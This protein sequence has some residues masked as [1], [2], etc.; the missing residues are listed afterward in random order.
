MMGTEHGGRCPGAWGDLDP[1]MCHLFSRLSATGH[2]GRIT[3]LRVAAVG[4]EVA[5]GA[6]AEIVWA[7]VVVPDDLLPYLG[8][9][10]LRWLRFAEGHQWVVLQSRHAHVDVVVGLLE[11]KR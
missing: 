2:W 3:V 1:K 9:Q 7:Q 11:K 5:L 4:A 6:E 8:P 10:R